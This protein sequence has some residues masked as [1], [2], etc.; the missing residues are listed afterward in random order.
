[1]TRLA[2]LRRRLGLEPAAGKAAVNWKE[3]PIMDIVK[4]GSTAR[5]PTTSASRYLQQ[6]CKHW[7]HN[8]AVEFTPDHGTIVFPRDARGAD[9][10]GDA[11]VTFDAEADALVTR[12]EATSPAQL[13][14]LKGA[15]ARHVDRFA[16]REAPLPFDWQD[17]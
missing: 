1:V 3:G 8:L 9:H 2:L 5:T 10:P 14:G 4:V 12:I 11:L 15:V 17:D 16:F 7:A 13:E 6:T